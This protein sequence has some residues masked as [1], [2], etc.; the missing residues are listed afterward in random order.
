MSPPVHI[1][2]QFWSV[3]KAIAETRPHPEQNVGSVLATDDVQIVG[4]GLQYGINLI[5]VCGLV[6]RLSVTG[7]TERWHLIG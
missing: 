3:L 6:E 1:D 2:D 7:G 5:V 4:D